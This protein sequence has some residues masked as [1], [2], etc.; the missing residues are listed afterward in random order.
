VR[1][2]GE[3]ALLGFA[4]GASE[5]AA[6]WLSFLRNLVQ[7]GLRGVQLVISDSHE[8]LKAALSQV[9]AGATWQRCRVHT[10]RTQSRVCG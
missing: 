9:L 10:I 7:R 5:E 2:T 6:F 3:R 8:G 1:E 4:V